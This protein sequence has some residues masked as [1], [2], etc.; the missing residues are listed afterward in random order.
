MIE[1]ASGSGGAGNGGGG[2]EL[3][4]YG[5]K[6]ELRASVNDSGSLGTGRSERGRG[7]RTAE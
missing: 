1:E 7:R 3:G 2:R 5:E 4:L 6:R